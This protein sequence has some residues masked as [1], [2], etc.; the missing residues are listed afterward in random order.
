MAAATRKGRRS[1]GRTALPRSA[2]SSDT[3]SSTDRGRL[4]VYAVILAG[5]RGERLWPRARRG[6]P[7]PF[8]AL[9]GGRTLFEATAARARAL[10]GR[11]RVLVV[12]GADQARWIRRQAPWIAPDRIVREGRSRNTAA[13]VAL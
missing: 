1:R 11:D 9:A 12:C 2:A 4:P 10:A 3:V 13:S 5:G 7:K 6:R 8:V